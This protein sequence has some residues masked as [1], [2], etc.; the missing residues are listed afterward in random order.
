[1]INL[2]E[3]KFHHVPGLGEETYRYGLERSDSSEVSLITDSCGNQSW[4]AVG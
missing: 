1:M 3:V 4:V 2:R